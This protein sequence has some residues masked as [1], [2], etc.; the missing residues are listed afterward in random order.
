MMKIKV[1]NTLA[2]ATFA[3]VATIPGLTFAACGDGNPATWDSS[4]YIPRTAKIG[5]DTVINA[6]V[7]I[8]GYDVI[9]T[10]NTIGDGTNAV[11]LGSRARLGDAVSI[12]GVSRVAGSAKVGNSVTINGATAGSSAIIGDGSSLSGA[13]Y[14]GDST[15][16]GINNILV[17]ATLGSSVILGDNVS[18]G[19]DVGSGPGN[20][21]IGGSSKIGY[22]QIPASA[23]ASG[24]TTIQPNVYIAGSVNLGIGVTVEDGAVIRNGA[25]IYSGVTIGTGAVIG[26]HDVICASV[27]AGMRLPSH[28]R[29]GCN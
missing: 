27:P 19:V 18:V 3:V 15:R 24:P 8:G 16:L 10:C 6:N 29:Y 25:R 5:L 21:S 1:R 13:S 28:Y 22:M 26:G 4:D 11:A 7:S 20:V 23:T 14:L 12:S 9:G 2:V 17:G